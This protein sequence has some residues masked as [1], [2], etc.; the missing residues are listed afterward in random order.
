MNK[1]RILSL[2]LTAASTA[3]LASEP[4]QTPVWPQQFTAEALQRQNESLYWT[5][6]YYDWPGG[7]NLI[8]IQKQQ[9]GLTWDME[10]TNGTSYYFNREVCFLSC[11]YICIFVT[12]VL[13][14]RP[15]LQKLVIYTSHSNDHYMLYLFCK[16]GSKCRQTPA[17]SCLF[18]LGC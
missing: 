18:P 2:L 11:N 15:F 16:R 14:C 13:S 9:G 7:R 5:K 3:C 17:R 12:W 4:P 6:L 10:W 1:P 8:I